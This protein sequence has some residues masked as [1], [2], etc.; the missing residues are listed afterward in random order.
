RRHARGGRGVG[1]EPARREDR[2]RPRDRSRVLT[3]RPR[4][5]S[6]PGFP[7]PS[8]PRPGMGNEFFRSAP[9]LRLVQLVT[10]GYDALDL[11]AA[12]KA[13]VPVANC[14]GSN[15][16]SVAEHT[17]TLMLAVL[18]RLVWQHNNVVAG[19]WRVGDF[20]QTRYDV[21]RLS[22]AEEDALGV[23]FVLFSELLAAS[24]VVSLH[25]PLDETTRNLMSTRELGMMKPGSVLIN[26]CRGPVVDEAALY[27]A[28]TSGPLA[29][30]G[31]DVLVEEP[32]K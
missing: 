30:A 18:K 19:K 14:G 21:R 5:S 28:L 23:R 25:V 9:R 20:A 16:V 12:R 2:R 1:G 26:T 8:S 29:A 22:G 15:A 32:A 4:S 31:L 27:T 11:E 3:W 6:R 7:R 17:M 13:G 24:D 10:A